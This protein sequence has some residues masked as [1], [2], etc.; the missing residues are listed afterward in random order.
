M[1]RRAFHLLPLIG[2]SLVFGAASLSNGSRSDFRQ[3][4]A[5]RSRD[6]A[7]QR[8]SLFSDEDEY[9][10]DDEEIMGSVF[11]QFL[12]DSE[13]QM[14]LDMD[15]FKHFFNY[16]EAYRSGKVSQ[17][18]IAFARHGA[19]EG[20]L[21]LMRYAV[22]FV[23]KLKEFDVSSACIS[24]VFHYVWTAVE[25]AT[26]VEEHRNCTDCK[27]TPFF[28]QKKNE[29][30]WIFNV[31]DAMGKVPPGI[32]SGNNLWVGS[33][34]TCRKIHV[35]KNSQGQL[36]NGMYCLAHLEAYERNNPLKALDKT[37]PV[38]AHC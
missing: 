34:N 37:G 38:D 19:E 9:D 24:D 18:T 8:P 5:S 26:H 17:V 32:T 29:R 22:K 30:S 12:A 15:F 25:Y 28:Q 33:W 16:A 7:T 27:C 10:E 23:D 6:P 21:D 4:L 36:W 1:V 11:T 31:L 13:T 35:V 20:N 3:S 2:L 14:I